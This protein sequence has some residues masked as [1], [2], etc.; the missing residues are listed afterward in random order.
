MHKNKTFICSA[1]AFG[2]T[3]AVINVLPPLRVLVIKCGWLGQTSWYISCILSACVLAFVLKPELDR[4]NFNTKDGRF[5]FSILIVDTRLL[6]AFAYACN[7]FQ[8]A[9]PYQWDNTGRA[10]GLTVVTCIFACVSMT[11]FSVTRSYMEHLNPV[12]VCGPI[13]SSFILGVCDALSFISCSTSIHI[14]VCAVMGVSVAAIFTMTFNSLELLDETDPHT[15]CEVF[16]VINNS[17]AV[18]Q[19][20]TLPIGGTVLNGLHGTFDPSSYIAGSV[21]LLGGLILSILVFHRWN[22]EAKLQSYN[23]DLFL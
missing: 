17:E 14:F 11:T 2:Y 16:V 10:S 4:F 23:S 12:M 6:F 13:I 9:I 5:Y 7:I 20:F 1:S 22:E 19:S 3:V 21:G 18:F 8:M 15:L